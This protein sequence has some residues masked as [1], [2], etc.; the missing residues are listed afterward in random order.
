MC[1]EF[2]VTIELLFVKTKWH[3]AKCIFFQQKEKCNLVFTIPCKGYSIV[4]CC[5]LS[6]S[7]VS[8]DFR[9]VSFS[10]VDFRHKHFCMTKPTIQISR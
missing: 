10:I 7:L 1:E 4:I 5:S 6:L 8:G 9:L 3:V 2:N